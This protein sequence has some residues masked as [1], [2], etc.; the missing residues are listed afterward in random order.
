LRFVLT[1]GERHDSTQALPLL[2]G[3]RGDYVLADKGYDADYIAKAAEN[4]GAQ[5]VIPSRSNSK[6]LRV[7]D[8]YLY[9][10]RNHIE[11]LF[12]KIKQFRRIATRYDKTDSAFL[13]FIP[14]IKP[15]GLP[16]GCS[17][18]AVVLQRDI[19]KTGAGRQGA[20]AA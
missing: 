1:G 20:S 5:A 8:A 2:D 11:R 9:K 18:P 14:R 10:E 7:Y 4:I 15:R 12:G 3:M 16:C 19:A 13:G 6:N 17:A